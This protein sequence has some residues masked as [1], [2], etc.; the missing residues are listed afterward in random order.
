MRIELISSV[1]Q[2][3]ALTT[4]LTTQ[5]SSG[6]WTHGR[7]GM[8]DVLYHSAILPAEREGFEPSEGF[9]PSEV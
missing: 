6:I 9:F 4:R 8:N 3:D 2:T 1:P 7:I 5:G